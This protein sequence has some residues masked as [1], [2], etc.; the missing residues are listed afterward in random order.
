MIRVIALGLLLAAAAALAGCVDR[1][2]N[3]LDQELSL[4]RAEQEKYRREDLDRRYAEER[5]RCDELTERILGLRRDVE[6]KES[7]LADLRTRLANLVREI[8]EADARLA[9]KG[10]AVDTE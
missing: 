1:G 9:A 6:G 3:L 10:S 8:A 5:A 4:Y 2:P 7:E